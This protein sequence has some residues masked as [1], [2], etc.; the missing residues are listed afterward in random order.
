MTTWARDVRDFHERFRLIYAGP[1]RSLPPDLAD[2]R[3][4]FLREELEEYQVA[5]DEGDLAGQLDALIDLIYV[6]LGTAH[7]HGFSPATIAE[8]WRR[9]HAANM[10]KVPAPSTRRN[11][12]A[13]PGGFD[14]AKP[15]GWE[16]PRFDDLVG[17]TEREEDAGC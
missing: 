1:P 13:R 5:A 2:F 3:A 4:R 15:P 14:V 6:A 9:V 12:L 10:K 8:A 16:P 17:A 11:G 7:L